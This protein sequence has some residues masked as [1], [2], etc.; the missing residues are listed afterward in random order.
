MIEKKIIIFSFSVFLT[1]IAGFITFP[2]FYRLLNEN[3]IYNLEFMS[4]I[5]F[6][7]S[8]IFSIQLN[9]AYSRDFFNLK[10]KNKN[11][12]AFFTIIVYLF[13]ATLFFYF[14]LLYVGD[15]LKNFS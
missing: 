15:T 5:F 11:K 7:L 13:F 3:Q 2:I 4:V 6:F 1:R 8:I 9:T 14:I 10:E 12:N